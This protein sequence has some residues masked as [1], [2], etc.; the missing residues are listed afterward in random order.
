MAPCR[1]PVAINTL[2]SLHMWIQVDKMI[3]LNMLA[4]F[5]K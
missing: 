2:R 3:L 4:K 5:A 1:A